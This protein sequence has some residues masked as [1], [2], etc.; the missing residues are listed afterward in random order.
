MPK[1]VVSVNLWKNFYSI[2][3]WLKH[4]VTNLKKRRMTLRYAVPVFSEWFLCCFYLS[5]WSWFSFIAY[6]G[7][8]FGSKSII[9]GMIVK[10][11]ISHEKPGS[12]TFEVLQRAFFA[13]MPWAE[14]KPLNGIHHSKWQDLRWGFWKFRSLVAKSDPQ[15][16]IKK[17]LRVIHKDKTTDD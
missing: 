1:R 2:C 10:L 8:Y 11:C 14:N 5:L 6:G 12:G 17:L 3:T 9:I 13:R 15:I 16:F 4:I 7:F